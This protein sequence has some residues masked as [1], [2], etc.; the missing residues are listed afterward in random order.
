MTSV[1]VFI[2]MGGMSSGC[3]QMYCMTHPFYNA[4]TAASTHCFNVN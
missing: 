2:K 4:V 3:K 1:V